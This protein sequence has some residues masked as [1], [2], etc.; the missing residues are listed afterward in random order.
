MSAA[1][2]PFAVMPRPGSPAGADGTSESLRQLVDEE[3]RRIVDE[4]YS[5]A[6]A[7]LEA[8]RDRLDALAHALLELETLDEATAYRIAGFDRP[9]TE[10]AIREHAFDGER[11][12][13]ATDTTVSDASV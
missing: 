7:L 10:V 5:E 9:S 13:A 8:H 4:C 3:V 6:V 1:V 2:G 12:K 11:Q